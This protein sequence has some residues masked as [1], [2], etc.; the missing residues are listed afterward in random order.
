M[1]LSR[2]RVTDFTEATTENI[3]IGCLVAL[4]ESSNGQQHHYA[5]LGAWD[6][7]PENDIL[8]Y[9]TPLAQQLLGKQKGETATTNIGGNEAEWTIL[10]IERWLDKK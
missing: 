8:S 3:G 1:D 10:N 7:D 9:K 5:I 6:S 4:K 2:A